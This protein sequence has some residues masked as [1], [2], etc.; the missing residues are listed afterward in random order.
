MKSSFFKFSM[1][2][3]DHVKNLQQMRERLLN[4]LLTSAFI[5]GTA[6]VAVAMIPAFQR[7]MYEFLVIYALIYLW[8]IVVTFVPRLPFNV[9]TGAWFNVRTTSWLSFF[10]VLGV[11][12]LY[13]SGFNA[14]AG[15]FFLTFV[16]MSAL[17]FDLRR[18][19]LA[20]GL[21]IAFIL[22]F[23]YLTVSGRFELQMETPQPADP[24]LW[25]IGGAVFLVTSM[26][27]II[28]LTVLV[29]GLVVNLAKATTEAEKLEEL[30]R[31]L[32]ASEERYRSLVEISPDLIVLIG[33][34]GNVIL[35]NSPGLA[36]FGYDRN[37]LLGNDFME[38]ILPE[39]RP[40]AAESLQQT[41]RAGTVKNI[42]LRA[43]RKDSSV[44]FAEFST[45][46]IRDG[47]GQPQA[48]MSVGR[49]F[50]ARKQAE[51]ALQ[52]ARDELENKVRDRTAELVSASERLRE[53]LARSPAVIFAARYEENYPAIYYSDNILE[54]MGYTPQQFAGDPKFWRDRIHPEDVAETLAETAR[55]EQTGMSTLEYRFLHQDGTYH[56]TRETVRLI[57]SPQGEPLELVG[58]WVDITAQRQAEVALIESEKKYKSL[59]EN[60]NVGIFQSTL[61]GKFIHANSAVIAMSGYASPD[62]F[63]Q[64][65]AQNMYADQ[66]DREAAILQLR[67]NGYVKNYEARSRKQDG[68]L[69]WVSMNAVLLQDKDG[70][71]TSIL[72]SVADI[73]ERKHA[74]EALADAK[75]ELEGRVAERTRELLETQGQLRNLTKEVVLAQEEERRHV[76]RELHDEAGQALVSMKYG[77]E[78]ILADLPDASPPV[79][80]RLASALQQLDQTMER[81]RHLAHSLRP[82]L[83]DVADL[84]LTLKDYCREFAESTGLQIEYSG[85]SALDLSEEAGL[86]FFRFLQEALTNVARHANATRVDVKLSQH[87]GRLSLSVADNGVGASDDTR[88]DGRGHIGMRERFLM[89]GG[90]V[91]IQSRGRSGFVITASIPAKVNDGREESA[92]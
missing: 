13:L 73:T 42:V 31:T 61:D 37:D 86:S 20:F 82:P 8:L 38:F 35:A 70:N 85:A 79:Q 43:L 77:L 40:L 25:I 6:L 17:L 1:Q 19:L 24:L 52:E 15:L 49:D 67:Q 7:G 11:I 89:L 72:G 71:P 12:N 69:Y 55:L 78:A 53:L 75:N 33:L 84:D 48:V 51:L 18:G 81:I 62:E 36:L 29:R 21:S 68:S 2:D 23:G 44:F 60:V 46:L 32:R 59:V 27:L 76:S 45:S 90:E 39:D 63:L 88:T 30:N 26:S 83:F 57:R 16:A 66:G 10:F 91:R 14:D 47:M 50:T 56:W 74:E 54:M 28:A 34:D 5:F 65:P 9:R 80:R 58:S 41:L 3:F 64:L 87:D 22:F 4:I 92:A